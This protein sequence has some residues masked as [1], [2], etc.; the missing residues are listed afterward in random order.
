M[1]KLTTSLPLRGFAFC[2]RLTALCLHLE[3]LPLLTITLLLPICF[4]AWLHQA[5]MSCVSG[6]VGKYSRTSW[7]VTCSFF[8][9][10]LIS[11]D[12]KCLVLESPLTSLLVIRYRS[13]HASCVLYSRKPPWSFIHSFIYSSSFIHSNAWSFKNYFLLVFFNM[14]FLIWSS[15]NQ[16]KPLLFLTPFLLLSFFT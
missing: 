5:F 13:L 10:C 2:L 3:S 8:H 7:W 15:S 16:S 11:T 14:F 1:W 4:W 12:N 6:H 9:D